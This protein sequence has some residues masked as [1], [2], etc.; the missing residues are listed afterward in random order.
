MKILVSELEK[1]IEEKAYF[2]NNGKSLINLKYNE[3]DGHYLLITTR[4]YK[5]LTKKL[6]KMKKIAVGS[7]KILITDLVCSQLPK[8]NNTKIIVLK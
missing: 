7:I 5:L 3:R 6:N 8:S 1:L 4:R 2:S